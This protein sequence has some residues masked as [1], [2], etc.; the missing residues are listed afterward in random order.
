MTIEKSKKKKVA[1][2]IVILGFLIW[3][4][5]FH[6][7]FWELESIEIGIFYLLAFVFIGIFGIYLKIW[8]I[9][10]LYYTTSVGFIVF[11]TME[12]KGAFTSFHTPNAIVYF[13]IELTLLI[14]IAYTICYLVA[15]RIR[16][17]R[18]R[19]KFRHAALVVRDTIDD[20][21]LIRGIDAT[22]I[23]P[24]INIDKFMQ[25]G[26]DDTLKFV[27][28][29]SS[30]VTE[31]MKDKN[32]DVSDLISTVKDNLKKK[33]MSRFLNVAIEIKEL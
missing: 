14:L 27:I 28:C 8:K 32:I 13:L 26:K 5:F 30:D 15:E 24:E 20:Y 11:I 2:F 22:S 16:R 6:L 9:R 29:V 7:R 18:I 25:T 4:R 3:L 21:L 19:Y 33:E 10:K 1:P 12:K 17:D 31:K 23:Y